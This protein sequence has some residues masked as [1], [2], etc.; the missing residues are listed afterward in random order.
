MNLIV[1]AEDAFCSAFDFINQ[2]LFIERSANR[3]RELID[4]SG[5]NG[6]RLL[7]LGYNFF[8]GFG[9]CELQA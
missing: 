5:A 9:I 6:L 1:D 3:K 7:K 2:P 8:V 4:E